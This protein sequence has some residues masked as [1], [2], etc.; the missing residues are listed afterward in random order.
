MI[1]KRTNKKIEMPDC[2]YDGEMVN[3]MRDGIGQA[4]FSDGSLFDGCWRNDQPNGQG[5]LYSVVGLE[6]Y[7]GN[8]VGGQYGGFGCERNT[9]VI[10]QDFS[11]DDFTTLASQWS[12][13][14]GDYVEGKWHGF[15]CLELINGEK[16]VGA[17]IN[18]LPNGIGVFHTSNRE[19]INGHWSH[20]HLIKRLSC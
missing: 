6:V 13:Y 3:C 20:G 7:R 10:Q 9:M 17:F 12:K 2:V 19:C 1:E 16:Y 8:F 5:V 18:G 14:S 11:F 4:I 15:G